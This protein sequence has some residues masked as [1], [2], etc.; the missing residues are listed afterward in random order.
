MAMVSEL[1]NEIEY[2]TYKLDENM[3]IIQVDEHFTSMTGYTPEDIKEKEIYQADLIFEE[4]R[5]KYFAMVQKNLAKSGE[6][7]IEHRIKCKDGS[8]RFV[9]CL[10]QMNPE[11]G[12]AVI[13]SMDVTHL[14]YMRLQAEKIRKENDD[15]IEEWM[16]IANTDE[17]TG[18]LRRGAFL[19]TINELVKEDSDYTL[20]IIDVDDFKDVNDVCGHR[21]GDNVLKALAD[22]F[23]KAVRDKDLICRI[24]GDEFSIFLQGTGNKQAACEIAARII[25][26]MDNLQ[27]LTEEKVPVHVSVG[28]VVHN[29]SSKFD[30]RKM[31]VD[32]DEA[33][34]EAKRNG[35][36]QYVIR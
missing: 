28:G 30:L 11:T 19:P 13:R 15:E 34:Y 22:V 24:G 4:D 16:Q 29:S 1:V 21:V 18:V 32:A 12:E 14:I 8:A 10:G 26:E 33:L 27:Y 25:R 6:A 7:Y 2:A 3:R 31:F 9:F 5:E 17:L 36:N 20:M 35:K 23:K